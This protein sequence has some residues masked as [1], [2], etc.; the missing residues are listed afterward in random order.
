MTPAA[1]EW[2]MKAEADFATLQRE[3]RARRKPNYDAA[4]FHAQQC[5]EKY[6]KDA[7]ARRA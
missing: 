6:I 1:V 4:C 2:I 3:C 7:C 5:V